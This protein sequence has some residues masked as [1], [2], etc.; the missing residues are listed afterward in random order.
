MFSFDDLEFRIDER[1]GMRRAR[2]FFKNG[3]G[4]S[5]IIGPYSYGGHEGLYELAV[6][7]KDG[8]LC[9]DTPI[10]DDVLGWLT[11]DDV[12]RYGQQVEAL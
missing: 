10:T 5:V 1:S 11:K 2:E 12:T 6:I 3:Y 8:S 9:Y 7:E 4:V